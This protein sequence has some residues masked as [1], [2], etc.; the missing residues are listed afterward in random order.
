MQTLPGICGLTQ[1]PSIFFLLLLLLKGLRHFLE[2]APQILLPSTIM[3]TALV[4]EL[5]LLI[6]C[7]SGYQQS[8][9]LVA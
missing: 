5:G 1:Q 2:P 8:L 7:H 9:S 4:L 6:S 3:V